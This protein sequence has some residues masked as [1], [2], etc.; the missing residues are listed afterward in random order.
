M[1][2]LTKDVKKIILNLF[3]KNGKNLGKKFSLIYRGSRDGWTSSNFH[4]KC[5]NK[6]KT[7]TIIKTYTNNI[8]G[9]YRSLPFKKVNEQ[10]YCADETAFLFLVRSSKN[11]QPQIFDLINKSNNHAVYDFAPN[12]D[13]MFAFGGGYDIGIHQ[14]CN[15]NNNSYTNNHSYTIKDKSQAYLNGG[16]KWFKVKEMEIFII[17]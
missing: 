9:A 12:Q 17:A 10:T 7:I 3:I 2:I 11:Y 6:S 13:R 8:F 15:Q 5:D 1:V 14:N 4:S 16:E